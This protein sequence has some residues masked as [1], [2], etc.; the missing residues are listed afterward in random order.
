[1]SVTRHLHD[2]AARRRDVLADVVGLDRQLAVAAVDQD[3]ELDGARPAEVDERVERGAGGAA[4]VEHVVD[5][6]DGAV[7]DRERDLGAPDDRL[8]AHR[9]PHQ[10]VAVEGDVEGAD[11]ARRR[12]RCS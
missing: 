3:D 11:A 4:G 9:L 10:V 5:Q 7:V 2:L 12:P 1:M 6:D 8:R